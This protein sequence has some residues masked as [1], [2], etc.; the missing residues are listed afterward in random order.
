MQHVYSITQLH[1]HT[2]THNY[3]I[4]NIINVI[5]TINIIL[6][7]N[8]DCCHG[9]HVHLI[10]RLSGAGCIHCVGSSLPS[11]ITPLID[12][13]MKGLKV[14]RGNSDGLV[15]YS[16]ALASLLSTVQFSE[17]GVP[18]AKAQEVFLFGMELIKTPANGGKLSIASVQ[19]GWALI[20]AYLSLGKILHTNVY[21]LL[22]LLSSYLII[23]LI[24]HCHYPLLSSRI[25]CNYP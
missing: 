3:S 22:S 21:N 5:S 9:N 11:L 19:S 24:I 20:G 12:Y 15:G 17:L 6:I 14:N 25:H 18:S 13:L 10:R 1:R 2:H 8:T 16:Y 4:F 23:H 7:T